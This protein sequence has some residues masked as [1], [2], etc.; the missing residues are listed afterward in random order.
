M[1]R[2]SSPANGRQSAAENAR[3]SRRVT[4]ARKMENSAFLSLVGFL[5]LTFG[6]GRR[7]AA[8]RF[9]NWELALFATGR[10]RAGGVGRG[11]GRAFNIYPVRA[12]FFAREFSFGVSFAANIVASRGYTRRGKF[13]LKM[14]LL[15]FYGGEGRDENVIN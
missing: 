9:I 6:G 13:I 7:V 2:H 5:R 11:R 15:H 8:G 4:R 10:K 3:F 12:R 1:T 14:K